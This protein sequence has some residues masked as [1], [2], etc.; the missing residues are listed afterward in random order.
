[1]PSKAAAAAGA[2]WA[3]RTAYNRGQILYRLAEMLESRAGELAA[4]L[5]LSGVAAA[6]AS[7]EVSATV[8]RLVY[9]AGLV[10]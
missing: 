4:C 7:R 3:R 10:G 6:A 2:G 8:D 9:Y 5:T 1:M